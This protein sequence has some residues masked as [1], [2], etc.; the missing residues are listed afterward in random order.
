ME[1]ENEIVTLRT[2]LDEEGLDAGPLTIQYHLRQRHGSAPRAGPPSTG[3][4]SDGASSPYDPRPKGTSSGSTRPSSAAQA[5]PRGSIAELQAQIDTFVRYYNEEKPQPARD[6]VPPRQAFDALANAIPDPDR[7]SMAPHTGFA[8]T[9][10]TRL[11]P[12]PSDTAPGST[13]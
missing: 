3:C 6:M 11:A 5:G 7:Y 10:S 8:T 9:R 1:L 13:T 12:S 2:Y 4:S